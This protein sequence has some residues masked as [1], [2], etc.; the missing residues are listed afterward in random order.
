[1]HTYVRF[2]QANP[3][4]IR[5]CIYWDYIFSY[6]G[7]LPWYK[8]VNLSEWQ[9]TFGFVLFGPYR[10]RCSIPARAQFCCIL[11]IISPKTL[12]RFPRPSFLASFSLTCRPRSVNTL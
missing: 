12:E 1:M 8:V 9:M 7:C 6:T 5:D 4:P 3:G 2:A 11:S 10:V